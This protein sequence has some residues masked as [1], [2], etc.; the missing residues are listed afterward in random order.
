MRINIIFCIFCLVLV[1]AATSTA[2]DFYVDNAATG[3]NKGTSWVNAWQSLRAIN[4]GSISGGDTVFISGGAT[5]KTYNEALS[6]GGAVSWGGVG[7]GQEHHCR[8][9]LLCRAWFN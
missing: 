1:N 9:Q 6:I 7:F 5:E 4:W 3:A 8:L 2:D